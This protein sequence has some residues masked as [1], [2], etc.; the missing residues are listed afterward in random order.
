[1]E[2]EKKNGKYIFNKDG[3]YFSLTNE[4]VVDMS[5][6]LQRIELE[7][8]KY[9]CVVNCDE[10]GDEQTL[11]NCTWDEGNINDCTYSRQGVTKDKC[12]YWKATPTAGHFN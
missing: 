5:E 6:T 3:V 11:P 12:E 1:M 8:N 7:F 2:Y 9:G 10:D 4:Q